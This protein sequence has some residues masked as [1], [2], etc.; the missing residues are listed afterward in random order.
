MGKT[1]KV[2]RLHITSPILPKNATQNAR[3]NNHQTFQVL[4][5]CLIWNMWNGYYPNT[6]GASITLS[7]HLLTPQVDATQYMNKNNQ[8]ALQVLN[9]CSNLEDAERMLP[10]HLQVLE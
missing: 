6:L 10:K 1:K 7:K 9:G 2:K 3:K 5:G 4:D 8:Q